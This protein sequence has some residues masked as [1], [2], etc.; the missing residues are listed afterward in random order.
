MGEEPYKCDICPNYTNEDTYI[1][2]QLQ[3]NQTG[4][5]KTTVCVLKLQQMQITELDFVP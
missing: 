3:Y 1:D 4:V 2:L 5:N